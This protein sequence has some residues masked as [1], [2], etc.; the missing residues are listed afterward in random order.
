MRPEIHDRDPVGNVPND[1]EIMSDE[2]IAQLEPLLQ[3]FEQ[4]DDLP[5]DRH[6][7]RGDRLVADD[8]CRLERER[9]RD[10]DALALAAGKL[11]RI[12]VGH[13]GEQ[14][15]LARAAPRRASRS[16]LRSFTRP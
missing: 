11:V 13:I 12:A 5:L 3:V 9:A 8:E 7:E 14:A 4:I 6:V 10:A 15:D 16:L 2:E 1:R